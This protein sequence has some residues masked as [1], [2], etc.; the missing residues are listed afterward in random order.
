LDRFPFVRLLKEYLKAKSSVLDG[1]TLDVRRRNL[2]R[3]FQV[4]L[5]LRQDRLIDTL[6]PRKFTKEE[7]DALVSWTDSKSTG[8]AAKLWTAIED[9]LLFNDN[10]VVKR[11]EAKAQWRR[12][13]PTYAPGSVKD[14]NW[15]QDALSKLDALNGWP[16]D[17]TKF[18]VAFMFGTGLRPGELRL[19]DLAD[20]ATERWVFK[21]MHPKDVPGAVVGTEL[22]GY[23]DTRVHV[24]DFLA[25]RERHLRLLGFEPDEVTALV[26]S[27]RGKHYSEAGFRNLRVDVFRR[28]GI[29]GDYRVL[30]RTHEQILMDRLEA[31]DYKEGSII[32]ISAKR[33]RHSMQTAVRHY[34]DL[35][36]GRGQRA[37]QEAWE[38]PIVKV[39]DPGV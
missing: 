8:Y 39:K 14:E 35:R 18:V 31:H 9:F 2:Q 15:L 25:A 10:D 34:A 29:Q 33:L 28:A 22:A 36:T 12:P 19:A 23:A 1:P 37:A 24:L 7:V 3:V 21:V 16:A 38:T 26:P 4:L 13:D 11:L 30:R 27:E 5:H 17:A 32:E 20:L 6:D